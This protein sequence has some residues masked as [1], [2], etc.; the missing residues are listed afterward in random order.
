[1]S[2]LDILS[3]SSAGEVSGGGDNN[4]S[5]GSCFSPRSV[6]AIIATVLLLTISVEL[7]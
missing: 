4:D 5:S 7:S 6:T 3:V 2:N 1:M